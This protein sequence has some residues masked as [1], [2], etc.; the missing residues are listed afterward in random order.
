M[1]E[2]YRESP[3]KNEVRVPSVEYEHEEHEKAPDSKTTPEKSHGDL[4]KTIESLQEHAK[5]EAR[6]SQDIKVDK[7]KKPAEIPYM[8]RELKADVFRRII[9]GAQAHLKGPDRV[10][11]KVIHN[12]TIDKASGIGAKTIARPWGLFVGGI[13]AFIGSL[14]VLY[15]AKHYGFSYNLLLFFMLFGAG[16]ILG[17]ALELTFRVFRRPASKS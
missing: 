7:E 9:H 4:S 12:K 17:T 1:P 3:E 11:S 13:F 16:F 15:A 5:K 14:V 10:L 2:I 6:G 8:T